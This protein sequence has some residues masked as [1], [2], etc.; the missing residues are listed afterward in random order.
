MQWCYVSGENPWLVHYIGLSIMWKPELPTEGPHI[1]VAGAP[2][3]VLFNQNGFLSD[4]VRRKVRPTFAN[5]MFFV[6]FFPISRCDIFQKIITFTLNCREKTCQARQML[7]YFVNLSSAQH[8]QLWCQATV[9]FRGVE[10]GLTVYLQLLIAGNEMPSGA[11][12]QTR[13]RQPSA[14][15]KPPLPILSAGARLH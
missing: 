13:L 11:D 6:Y 5:S 4:W 2:Q 9:A 7:V 14:I 15:F 8:S 12:Q 3:C 10:G 1:H